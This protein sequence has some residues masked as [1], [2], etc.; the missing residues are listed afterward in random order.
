MHP[1]CVQLHTLLDMWNLLREGVEVLKHGR[2]GNPKFKTLLCDVNLTKLYWRSQGSR[3]DPDMD[4]L[5]EDASYYPTLLDPSATAAVLT[6]GVAPS[7]VPTSS[8]TN[9]HR[10]STPFGTKSN[11]DRVLYIRDI[12]EVSQVATCVV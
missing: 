1:V 4:N 2:R 5:P 9:A 7:E 11:A 10:L 8:T 6:K 3:A 12:V